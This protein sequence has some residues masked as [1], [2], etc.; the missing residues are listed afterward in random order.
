[1]ETSPAPQTS[2]DTKW[3]PPTEAETALWNQARPV[4]DQQLATT[5][6]DKRNSAAYETYL[7][8]HTAA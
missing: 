1:M 6:L 4:A 5:P 3:T 8:Y 2:T 7:N